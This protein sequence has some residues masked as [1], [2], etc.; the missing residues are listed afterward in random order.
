MSESRGRVLISFA[1]TGALSSSS[2]LMVRLSNN[3]KCLIR[4]RKLEVIGSWLIR[5]LHH[6]DTIYVYTHFIFSL[7]FITKHASFARSARSLIAVL[8]YRCSSHSFNF[9]ANVST[10]ATRG[11]TGCSI[12]D[13]IRRAHVGTMLAVVVFLL[14]FSRGK[15]PATQS[16]SSL[17]MLRLYSVPAPIGHVRV[18]GSSGGGRGLHAFAVFGVDGGRRGGQRR[19]EN[20]ERGNIE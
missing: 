18:L 5:R 20:D 13:L 4:K 17:G 15:I 11:P 3:H 10:T 9:R 1:Q 6:F 19:Q 2:P 8:D 16:A 14:S 7:R 12:T